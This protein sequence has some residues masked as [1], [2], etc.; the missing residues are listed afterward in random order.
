MQVK[1]SKRA[2]KKVTAVHIW[3]RG[4]EHK[5]FCVH[6]CVHGYVRVR[7]CRLDVPMV[8]E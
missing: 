3:D 7:A 8:F 6:A 2:Q 5:L 4:R 1:V